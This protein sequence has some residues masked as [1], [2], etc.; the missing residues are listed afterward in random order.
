MNKKIIA[1]ATLAAI[2]L[3]GISTTFASVTNTGTTTENT[4]NNSAT[5]ANNNQENGPRHD[6]WGMAHMDG[7]M[8]D[9]LTDAEKTTLQSL[10]ETEKKAFFEKKMTEE[11]AKRDKEEAII[12]KLLAGTSLTAEEE[13]T[14]Q[15]IIKSR[16]ERKTKMAEMEQ[17]RTEIEAILKKKEAGTTLTADEEKILSSMPARGERGRHMEKNGVQKNNTTPSENANNT[18]NTA[19]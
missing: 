16:A 9:N 18:E 8:M 4:T 1:G 19:K 2:G 17:K 6:K 5:V 14:R 11:K 7:R 13:T 3:A 10:S 12:D 15:E